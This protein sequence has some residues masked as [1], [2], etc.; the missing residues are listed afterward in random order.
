MPTQKVEI[1]RAEA[2]RRKNIVPIACAQYDAAD[3]PSRS[4]PADNADD[5]DQKQK[6]SGGTDVKR[7]ERA[8]THQEVKPRQAQKKFSYRH[9]GFVDP[10]SEIP[11]NGS[12]E[13]CRRQSDQGS[14]QTRGQRDL[15][16]IQQSGEF[17][18]SVSIGAQQQDSRWI[19]DTKQ[20][21]VGPEEPQSAVRLSPYE[22][23]DRVA[24]A[25]IFAITVGIGNPSV[26]KR[27]V[28]SARIAEMHT[29]GRCIRQ[30]AV[31]RRGVVR[32]DE[33]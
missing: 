18:A 30:I 17:V 14:Q 1:R 13:G 7:Q 21:P 16:A 15:P 19:V 28:P 10:P 3:Q 20:V 25:C 27:Q 5:S 6:C 11:G 8:C 24:G 31:L 32:R 23:M 33:S 4:R 29:S 26:D 22:E 9:Q 2:T 12:Y